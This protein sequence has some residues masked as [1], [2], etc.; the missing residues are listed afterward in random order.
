MTGTHQIEFK[1][2]EATHQAK[3]RKLEY[4]GKNVNLM[5]LYI[6]I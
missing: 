2:C 1:L 4:K 3:I 6:S 5:F